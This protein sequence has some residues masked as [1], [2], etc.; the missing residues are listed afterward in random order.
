MVITRGSEQLLRQARRSDS[1]FVALNYPLVKETE[2]FL[3]TDGVALVARD[4]RVLGPAGFDDEDRGGIGPPRI[5]IRPHGIAGAGRAN[6]GRAFPA[7]DPSVA[8][9]ADKRRARR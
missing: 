9:L 7:D 4:D 1:D 5:A 6:R 3:G 2:N 8:A